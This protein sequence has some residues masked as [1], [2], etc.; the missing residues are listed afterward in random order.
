MFTNINLNIFNL[1]ELNCFDY[2][3]WNFTLYNI[4]LK[5]DTDDVFSMDN[6]SHVHY[7]KNYMFTSITLRTIFY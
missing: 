3:Y 4:S 7:M 2:I 6:V 1:N 5:I